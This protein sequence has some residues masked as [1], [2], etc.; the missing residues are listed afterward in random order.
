LV[1]KIMG[2]AARYIQ[3]G[4]HTDSASLP[5]TVVNNSK[6]YCTKYQQFQITSRLNTFS[7]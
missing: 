3:T 6:V 7:G 5:V 2:G 4:Q 1:K